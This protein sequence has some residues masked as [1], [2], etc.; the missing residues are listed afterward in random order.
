MSVRR[1][2]L[3]GE[4]AGLDG[5]DAEQRWLLDSSAWYRR[6]VQRRPDAMA[7]PASSTSPAE[8]A[9]SNESEREEVRVSGR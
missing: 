6:L 9:T 3:D 8:L 4:E 1:R 7:P 5:D 2:G